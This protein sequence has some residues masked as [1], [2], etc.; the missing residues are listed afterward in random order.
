MR[1]ILTFKDHQYYSASP[2][3][4]KEGDEDQQKRIVLYPID[5]LE[6]KEP[7][8]P[9]DEQEIGQEGQRAGTSPKA[10]HPVHSALVLKAK[11]QTAY[12]LQKG[13]HDKKQCPP[14]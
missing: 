11:Q 8:M 4:T 1:R 2:P 12:I 10:A 13:N 3:T 9:L 5:N 14:K 7:L 6:T